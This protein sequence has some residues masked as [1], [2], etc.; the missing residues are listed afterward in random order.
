L[1]TETAIQDLIDS[2]DFYYDPDIDYPDEI[3]EKQAVLIA[4]STNNSNLLNY[5]HQAD[6][7]NIYQILKSN[8]YDDDHIILIIADDITNRLSNKSSE[9]RVSPNGENLYHDITIDYNLKDISSS[10]LCDILIGNQSE[11]LKV[12]ANS[13]KPPVLTGDSETDIFIFW[14]GHGS[15]INDDETNGYL[16]W[17]GKKPNKGESRNLTKE[18]LKNTIRKMHEKNMYRKMFFMLESCYA[19]S[20]AN[21]IESE[22]FPGILCMAAS[23]GKEKAFADSYNSS[24]RTYMTNRFT[25][26]FLENYSRDISFKDLYEKTAKA[27]TGSHVQILNTKF[28]GQLSLEYPA[29]FFEYDFTN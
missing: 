15:N 19:K 8:G 3:H 28:Y 7:L 10:D 6:T 22:K 17:G 16:S 12:A 29:E 2:I 20:I 23:N 9:V 14:S 13:E 5:R 21:V 24:L 18:M 11:N 25:H 26:N 1:E 4:A 27:T